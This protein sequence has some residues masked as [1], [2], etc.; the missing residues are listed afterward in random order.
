MVER[1][2]ARAAA[3]LLALLAWTALL[4]QLDLT[5]DATHARGGSTRDAL[6]LYTGYFTI[7][8]NLFVALSASAQA[9]APGSRFAGASLR[10]CAT[11]AIVLVGIG[12][13]LLLREIW[14]PQGWQRIADNLLHYA[15]PVAA[16]AHWLWYPPRVAMPA[17]SPLAW[18]AYPALYFAYA[19]VRGEWI[20]QYPYPFV[21]VA[22]LGYPRVFANAGG[23]LLV[24]LATGA[25]LRW[26]ASR[27]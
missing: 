9:W 25:L 16:L 19:L 27:R 21:D 22:T 14:D 2:G 4:L 12:Y 13:H 18:M 3:V 5:L 6:V 7:L 11:T 10:G 23:L 1:R 24:Y 17:W 26:L 20:G 15:V 8:S